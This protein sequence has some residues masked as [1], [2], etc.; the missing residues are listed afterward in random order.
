M[1]TDLES[2]EVLQFVVPRPPSKKNNMIVPKGGRRANILGSNVR[3]SQAQIARAAKQASIAHA[4]KH[5]GEPLML[6][7]EWDDVRDN[8]LV[9]VMK[10]NRTAS[11]RPFDLQNLPE[12]ICD[13]LQKAKVIRNDKDFLEIA[14]RQKRVSQESPA[15]SGL[16][17]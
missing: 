13:A 11:P 12:V 5:E 10:I 17:L 6:L 14:V 8:V 15:E 4:W 7:L 16:P 9:R 2:Y 1:A 3:K